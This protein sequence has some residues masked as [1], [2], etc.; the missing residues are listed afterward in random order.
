M[1]TVGI[2]ILG[3]YNNNHLNLEQVSGIEKAISM[4]AAKYGITLSDTKK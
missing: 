3:N 4:M 1:G 2:A